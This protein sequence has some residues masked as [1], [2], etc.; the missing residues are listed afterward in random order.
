[1]A[2]ERASITP[3]K[4]QLSVYINSQRVGELQENNGLWQ[5]HY[6]EDW[7]QQDDACPLAPYLPLRSAPHIDS[8]SE[9]PV[10]W[11][12][13]NL[14]PEEMA[15]QLLAK[16]IRVSVEDA[17]GILEAIGGE[18]AG[19]IT[20]LPLGTDIP[21]GD[22]ALLSSE[23]LSQRI[24]NLPRSPM[25][26]R[27][28]K[29]I[30]LAG[31]QHKMLVI[32]HKN[33]LY[34]PVGQTPSTHILKPEHSQPDIYHFTVRNEYTVMQLAEACGLSV[35]NVAIEYVPEACYIIERF[36][37]LGSFPDI[38]RMH[39]L[40]GCQLL[41]LSAG[42]KYRMNTIPTLL[43]LQQLCRSKGL[44]ALRLFRWV[45]FNFFTGNSDAHLKNLSFSYQ[46]NGIE[47]LPHYDLLSTIF[48]AET[49]TSMNEELS[50]PLGQATKFGQV[51]RTD[52][53]D[54]AGQFGLKEQIANREINQMATTLLSAM[55]DELEKVESSPGYKGKPGE[56]RMLRLIKHVAVQPLVA[57]VAD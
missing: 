50:Q 15:R 52:L 25:N 23:E 34:E 35:P 51:T 19:A 28:R 18:S 16:E 1:M 48:Y 31:A 39:V 29:R 54:V 6:A 20:L 46:K 37:R 30:S 5:F 32:K 33:G 55:Y 53:I 44:T 22:A 12:F 43:Q 11:F 56:L 26:D 7:L 8:G 9:R 49:G 38:Q 36:D 57:Q 45:L 41:G 27:R 4:R 24:R 13:D 47:L 40:D 10:Q 21:A 14:L 3:L 2:A 17:F 42:A